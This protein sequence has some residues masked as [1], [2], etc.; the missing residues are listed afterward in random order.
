MGV[1]T[2]ISWLVT[3]F[4]GL[5][6]L[7]VWPGLTMFTRWI[8]VHRAFAAT[9]SGPGHLPT[10]LRCSAERECPVSVVA[11]H[12]VLAAATVTLVLLTMLQG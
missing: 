9:E 8:P 5:Y 3:A 6:L 4:F 10:D 2:L 1:A 12:G 7:A 11:G